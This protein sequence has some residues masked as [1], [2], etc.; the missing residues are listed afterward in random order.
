[1]LRGDTG[2]QEFMAGG[3]EGSSEAQEG[4]RMKEKV[5]RME[6][7]VQR[8]KEKVQSIFPNIEKQ[9]NMPPGLQSCLRW[10]PALTLNIIH[11]CSFSSSING[12]ISS[13]IPVPVAVTR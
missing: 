9:K 11:R 3:A 2:M 5:Q 1:M 12:Q 10:D 13:T 8:M 7:N 4:E 6:E